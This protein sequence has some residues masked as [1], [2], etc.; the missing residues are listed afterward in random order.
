M[1]KTRYQ[2]LHDIPLFSGID[3]ASF[4][5][6]CTAAR[7]QRI[8]KGEFLFN[9]GSPADT[10][11]LIQKGSIKLVSNTENGDEVITQIIGTGKIL[12]ETALFREGIFLSTSAIILEESTVCFLNRQTFESIVINNPEIALKI[13]KC[14]GRRLEDISKHTTELKTQS[15]PEKVISLF[16]QL[17]EQYGEPLQ[18]GTLIKIHLTQQEIAS[19]IGASRVMVSQVLQQLTK[20]NKICKKNGY[21]VLIKKCIY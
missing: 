20:T 19:A 18:D 2:C 13:I 15:I 4:H 1:E 12:G 5:L 11:Y 8:K 10:I 17:A 9:Q 14:L 3:N 16:I 6:F 7:K 21:Y